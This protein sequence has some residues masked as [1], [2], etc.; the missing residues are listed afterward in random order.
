MSTVGW[1]MP[2]PARPRGSSLPIVRRPGPRTREGRIFAY[3]PGCLEARGRGRGPVA[4][5]RIGGIAHG[6]VAHLRPTLIDDPITLGDRAG[7]GAR[8]CAAFP[9]IAGVAPV[10]ADTDG[11]RSA[12]ERAESK[13]STPGVVAVRNRR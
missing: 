7:T 1:R 11:V 8:I 13:S 2:G 9:S 4:H 5:A 12:G 10:R 6:P 3:P